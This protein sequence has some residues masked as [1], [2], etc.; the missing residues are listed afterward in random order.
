MPHPLVNFSEDQGLPRGNLQLLGNVAGSERVVAGQH[1]HLHRDT[2]AAVKQILGSIVVSISACHA[3]DPGS[4]PGRGALFSI[5]SL[6]ILKSHTLSGI[7]FQIFSRDVKVQLKPSKTISKVS[8]VH[9][10]SQ[11]SLTLWEE[12]RRHEMLVLDSSFRGQEMARNPANVRSLSASFL[13][14]S[15]N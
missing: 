7:F 13:W 2:K 1:D 14:T 8:Y 11:E 6:F 4:I 12:S 15:L 3:E 10:V 5:Q 9:Y